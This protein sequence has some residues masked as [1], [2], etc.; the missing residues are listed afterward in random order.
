VIA[1]NPIHLAMAQFPLCFIGR[2]YY[3]APSGSP[4][5]QTPDLAGV[6]QLVTRVTQCM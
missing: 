2:R 3:L 1:W 4:P 6:L 5:A